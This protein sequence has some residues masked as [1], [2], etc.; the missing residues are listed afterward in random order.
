MKI[1][2]RVHQLRVQFN[3]TPEIT[4]YVYVYIIT[5]KKRM[6]TWLTQG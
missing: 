6:F 1:N 2:D 4:R 3:I 5:G